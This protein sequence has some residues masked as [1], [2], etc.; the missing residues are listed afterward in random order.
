MR[1]R[2]LVAAV[3]AA[4]VAG[5]G[6]VSNG[7]QATAE[8]VLSRSVKVHGG[9]A[10]GTWKTLTLRGR[11]EMQDGIKYNA[12]FLLQAKA[13]GRVRVEQDMTADRGRI[14]NDLFLHDGQA[15]SR[16]NLV[17]NPR[18]NVK[19]MM[20]FL[21]HCYGIAYYAKHGTEA[22]L[23]PDET[24]E[25]TPDG[26]ASGNA[27][28]LVRPAYVVTTKVDGETVKLYIDKGTYHLIQETYLTKDGEQLRV[29][30]RRLARN[31]K[32]FGAVV[33]PTQVLDITVN[34]EGRETVLPYSY[35][36]V[37]FDLPIEDWVFEEDRPGRESGHLRTAPGSGL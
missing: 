16:R 19:Q 11:V 27:A 9:E 32:A 6:A 14:T 1:S 23:G 2:W 4:C 21:R 8:D 17:V 34:R 36:S 10:A 35:D 31:F 3:L 28:P 26:A 13:P 7:A 24:V 12:A 22:S 25:W 20:R 29:E 33:F 5:A 37:T 30:G 18:G 15:W